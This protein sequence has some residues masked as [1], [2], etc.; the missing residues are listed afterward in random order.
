MQL[1]TCCECT[2]VCVLLRYPVNTFLIIKRRYISEQ[3]KKVLKRNLKNLLNIL[4][5]K[6]LTQ[7][8]ENKENYFYKIIVESL[9]MVTELCSGKGWNTKCQK[10]RQWQLFFSFIIFFIR[11]LLFCALCPTHCHSYPL[12]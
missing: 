9:I 3:K 5:N 4:P 2:R 8:F 6:E 1:F 7:K 12:H 11:D 10:A